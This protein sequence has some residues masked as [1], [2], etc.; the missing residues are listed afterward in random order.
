M[1]C[2]ATGYGKGKYEGEKE[3]KQEGNQWVP[4]EKTS[5]FPSL[6]LFLLSYQASEEK[7][8]SHTLLSS[9]YLIANI[10]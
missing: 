10:G 7:K 8:N 6:T 1:L 3:R 5:F 2:L 9:L 4:E